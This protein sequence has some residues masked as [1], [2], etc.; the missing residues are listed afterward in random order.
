[1]KIFMRNNRRFIVLTAVFITAALA[2]PSAAL[3]MGGIAGTSSA[4]SSDLPRTFTIG[5]VD[6]VGSVASLNPNQFTMEAEWMA[7]YPCYSTLLQYDREGEVTGDLARSWTTSA[8]GMTWHFDLVDNAYFVDPA[9]PTDVSHPV[10]AYDIIFTYTTIQNTPDSH[11]AYL[12]PGVIADIWAEGPFALGIELAYPF[13]PFQNALIN[14]PILPEYVWSEVNIVRFDNLPPIGSGPFYYANDDL[15]EIQLTLKR[16][17]IWHMEEQRGWKLR[18]DE[19]VIKNCLNPATAWLDL[20]NGVV[21]LIL[22]VPYSI[23]TQEVPTIPDVVGFAHPGGFVYEFNLNQMSDELRDDL[24]GA[25][26]VGSNNQL[27]LDPVVKRAMAMCIDKQTFV[28]DVLWGLGE[29][30]DS[31]VPSSSAWHYTYGEAPGEEVIP[32][33]TAAAR[34]AL[35]A[36]GWAYDMYGA[37]ASTDTV[38]LCKVGGT[39]P[40]SFDFFTLASAIEW[41]EGAILI[42]DRCGEAGIELNLEIMSINEMNSVWYC[43]DYDTWLWDWIFDPLADP[44]TDILSVMTTMEI[45]SW[46]DCYWSNSTYDE[47]Y[48]QSVVEMDPE[49]R[50]G[51]LNEMQ[52]ML[53]EDAACQC[54]AYRDNTYAASLLNWQ[55]YGDLNSSYMLLPDVTP[56]WLAMSISPV[57]NPAPVVMTDPVFEGQVD[58][59]LFVAA[60]IWDPSADPVEYRWFWGDGSSTSWILGTSGAASH[61]YTSAGT[62]EAY[63][64]AREIGGDELVTWDKAEVII[65]DF[66]NTAPHV[67]TGY[68]PITYTPAYPGV[69]EAILFESHFMDDEGD[70]LEYTWTFGDDSGSATGQNVVHSYGE[71]GL[72]EVVL[73]VTDNQVGIGERPVVVSVF[74]MVAEN[75][76]P[77]VEVPDFPNVLR[78]TEKLFVIDA[79]DADSDDLR[80][81]WDWGDRTVTVTDVPYAT[82]TYT[83]PRTF[84]LTVYVDDL[85]GL[86]GHNVSDTGLVNV[87]RD[88]QPPVILEFMVSDDLVDVGEEI[89]FFSVAYDPEGD[90]MEF[91]LHFDDG[92]TEVFESPASLPGEIVAFDSTKSYDGAGYYGAV[93]YVS[94]GIVTVASETI[95]IEVVA[96]DPP[97][98]YPLSDKTASTGAEI[99][100]AAY[101]VDPDMDPLT[102]TWDFGDGSP[103]AVGQNVTHSY[104]LEGDYIFTVYVDDG[105]GNNVSEWAVAHIVYEQPV[106][107]KEVHYYWYDMFATPFQEWWDLRAS[108]YGNWI[109]LTDSYPYI[110]EFITPSSSGFTEVVMSQM[111]LEVDAYN[112]TTVNMDSSPQFLPYLGTERGGDVSIYWYLDYLDSQEAEG[113]GPIIASWN[114][115]FLMELNGSV[116][117]DE[118]AAKSVLGITESGLSD[119]DTW[120]LTNGDVVEDTFAAWMD[121]EANER[122]DIFC[123]YE[124]PLT[125]LYWNLDAH[126]WEDKIILEYTSVTWGIEALM[127]KWLRE[128]FMPTEWW[129]G[130]DMQFYAHI[131]DQKADIS[132]DTVVQDSVRSY[133]SVGLNGAPCWV[134]QGMLQDCIPS[135]PAHLYSDFDPY[136]D[137]TLL[138][139][140]PGSPTYGEMIPYFYTPGSFDLTEGESLWFEMP[141]GDQMFLQH[142]DQGEY[143]EVYGPMGVAYSEPNETDIGASFKDYS[144]ANIIGYI[145]PIDFLNWSMGQTAHDFLA[146]EW[147]RLGVLPYGMP[148]VEFNMLGTG[149]MPPVADAGPDMTVLEDLPV[150]LDGTNSYDD[151]GITHYYWNVHE[152]GINLSDG[153]TP[154]I[155]LTDPG[156]YTVSLVVEDTIGQLSAPDLMTITVV[157]SSG[158]IPH[159]PIYIYGDDDFTAENGVI[160][161]TG[162]SGDP[163]LIGGWDI[164]PTEGDGITVM[165]TTKYFTIYNTRVVG[166][167]ETCTYGVHIEE[168]E[169]AELRDLNISGF[170]MGVRAKLTDDLTVTECQIAWSSWGLFALRCGSIY[171]TENEIAHNM[172]STGNHE[173]I[174]VQETD[175]A[176]IASNN[177]VDNWDGIFM[178]IVSDGLIFDN[179]MSGNGVGV[180]ALYSGCQ[181]L[182]NVISSRVY[183]LIL[184][185]CPDTI[186]EGNEITVDPSATD[187]YFGIMFFSCVNL[188][189]TGNVVD[190]YRNGIGTASGHSEYPDSQNATLSWNRVSDCSDSGINVYDVAGMTIMGNA[191]VSNGIGVY[192]DSSATGVKVYHNDLVDNSV[193]AS[194]D[195]LCI[196][197]EWDDGYPSGGNYWSDYAGVDLYSGP[198]QDQPGSDGIGDTPYDVSTET[199][200]RYPLMEPWTPTGPGDVVSVSEGM[201]ITIFEQ[202]GAVY[203]YTFDVDDLMTVGCTFT[204]IAMISETY[205]ITSDGTYLTI[206]CYRVPP[207]PGS[208]TATGNNIVAVRLDGV[209][210]FEDGIWASIIV[211]YTI[212]EGG[213]EDSVWNAL[214]P[215]DQVGPYGDS[216]CTYLGD[217]D[218]EIVLGFTA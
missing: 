207:S 72:Y 85:T 190:S 45:G 15:P 78:K 120:W 176:Y 204:T 114:D 194:V 127:T 174:M 83:P 32:F 198:M 98:V 102:Y 31:L 63:V 77:I 150:T 74:V 13:A 155:L 90:P 69:D 161:G 7:V 51:I 188:E 142:V 113:Y 115:G 200:D 12:L 76:P 179:T 35:V 175:Y 156:I 53:Y 184:C 122:L 146:S 130:E 29:P 211:D 192:I 38:P 61:V 96:N 125:F 104:V 201:S 123:M 95:V 195:P 139:R 126:E 111:R 118:Q 119:F 73:S 185:I 52:A 112:I 152:L 132:F 140:H 26:T 40:L 87:K 105:H 216:L 133:E 143:S 187:P 199:A 210:G 84:E 166:D 116:V 147:D 14:I 6:F 82:H 153:P 110:Y 94:D 186:V 209:P 54:V 64:A 149:D 79:Y 58:E 124:Y 213:I 65:Y 159:A 23:F 46:S 28:D 135:M 138:D 107:D 99:V 196:G 16:N 208:G 103:L 39:E 49:V 160:G 137:K 68:D 163:Y 203:S 8:D 136:A 215:A 50:R 1:M 93:L 11:L 80:Y 66:S 167:I 197:I 129:V 4:D 33:D 2:L 134:W 148:F 193:Q 151:V 171:V 191:L 56:T 157:S 44:S 141:E 27:L 177:L 181:V 43:A 202:T 24:G 164:S 55:G 62:Y 91:T 218:S 158:Y 212:G 214:G 131:T 154:V 20:Q 47:L 67:I 21:D 19:W 101:A 117:M 121:Y 81:T 59:P 48:N 178:Y 168:V 162:T 18:V 86:P 70:E 206:H 17:P 42:R 22:D 106:G 10:T 30:A 97:V 173:G 25:F 36:A 183:G 170:W 57:D 3:N 5:V 89:G 60:T 75:S 205:T 217:Y 34:N 88:N 37:P 189:V 71:G 100:F 108:I 180:Q 92:T 109:P 169:H 9:N 165:Y 182:D 41:E 144:W 172:V 128:A 145:G